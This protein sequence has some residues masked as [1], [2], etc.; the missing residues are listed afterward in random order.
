[1]KPVEVHLVSVFAAVPDG[2]N[3]APIVTDADG[4]TDAEMRAIAAAYGHES[5]FVLPAPENSSCDFA[6]RFWVPNHEM[7]MCGHATVGA[8]WL[9]DRL[10]RLPRD[11]ITIATKSGRVDARLEKNGTS[12]AM[13]EINQPKGQVE[14][15]PDPEASLVEI[16]S[17]LGIGTEDLAPL[18][19]RNARTSRVKTLIPLKSVAV[20]DGLKPDFGR[21]EWICEKIGSTGLY[22][23]AVSGSN[24]FD[25]R[26]FPKSSGYPE[27]AATGIAAA[28]LAFGLL[29]A[30]QATA[31]GGAIRVR[32]G[33]AMGR[34]SEIV[35]RFETDRTGA[36][37][38]CWLGGKVR[39]EKVVE[40]PASAP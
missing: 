38:G 12:D 4:L 36:V 10:G 27:D 21:V 33:R 14:P 16:L 9:L 5:A 24:I 32:Q 13:V 26:Q 1:M 2:G 8:V 37:S 29:E 11:R 19:V 20:L 18:P 30:G 40:F 34:D 3:P 23:F 35:V 17:V 6:L 15:L 31:T 25:A 22:P 7:E 39:F 28:A